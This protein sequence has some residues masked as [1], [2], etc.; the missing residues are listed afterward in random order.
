MC[1]QETTAELS[2]AGFHKFIADNSKTDATFALMSE[3]FVTGI[4]PALRC[5]RKGLR[6]NNARAHAAARKALLCL[7]GARNA[8]K[9]LMS[10]V[11]EIIDVEFRAPPEIR[12]VIEKFRSYRGEGCVWLA[13]LH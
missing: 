13:L 7:V 2:L 10:L 5:Q 3:L 6:F 9:Y 1:W 8:P 11:L 4:M 12:A